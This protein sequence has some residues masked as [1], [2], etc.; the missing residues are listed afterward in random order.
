MNATSED[1]ETA[2][3]YISLVAPSDSFL[4]LDDDA[5][6]SQRDVQCRDRID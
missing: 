2:A 1:H 3:A 6:P 5:R 4:M